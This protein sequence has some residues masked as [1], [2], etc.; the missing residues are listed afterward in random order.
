MEDFKMKG[1]FSKIMKIYTI[2]KSKGFEKVSDLKIY[3]NLSFKKSVEKLIDDS[4]LR[5]YT[6]FA[7]EEKDE[8]GIWQSTTK[9]SNKY[10]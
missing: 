9:S 10:I 7:R 4:K 8:R 6:I 3:E 2:E 1:N 5:I